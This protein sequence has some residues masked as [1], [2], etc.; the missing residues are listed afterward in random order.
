MKNS[1]DSTNARQSKAYTATRKREVNLRRNPTLHFQIGLILAL[2]TSIFFIEMRM[3]EKAMVIHTV[4]QTGDPVFTLDKF[5]VEKKEVKKTTIEKVKELEQ[6]KFI[7]QAPIV[8]DKPEIVETILT[9]TEV[10]EDPMTNPGDVDY[11]TG[12]DEPEIKDPVILDLVEEVPLFPGCEGLT[13]NAER[14]DCMSSKISKFVSKKFRT[15]KGEGRGL[16]GKNR[17]F[18]T[19]MIDKNGNVVD[20]KAR[21]PHKDLENEAKRVI[22]LLPVMTPGKQQGVNVPVLFTLP[23]VFEIQD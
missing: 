9:K 16:E 18:A 10:T 8:S 13:N 2:L 21:A 14:R 7:E 20:I 22:D 12:V 19:F 17:I 3:P 11:N 6:P 15:D 5:L 23:I 1:Q 4:E